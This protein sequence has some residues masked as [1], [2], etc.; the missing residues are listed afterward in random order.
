MACSIAGGLSLSRYGEAMELIDIGVNLSSD[1]FD[2]DREDVLERALA[3]G[4]C[5]MMLTG[6]SLESS[7]EA[8]ERARSRPGVLFATA[9]VH[10]HEASRWDPEA[11]A[12]IRQLAREPE[13]V[14]IGECG[15]DFNR[16]Y[17]PRPQQEA[18]FEAQLAIAA[19]VGLP[20][21]LHE[22]DSSERFAEILGRWRSRLVGG[23]VH[24]FT[25]S[26]SALETWLEM[27][28]YI[29]VTG[30]ICDERRGQELQALVGQI[31]LDRLLLETDAPWLLP[32]DLRPRPAKGRNEPAFLAHICAAVARFGGHSS[33]KLARCST[34]NARRLFGLA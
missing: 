21:F 25:G 22:R 23:V 7:R 29:G 5:Q 30:W 33:E 10:P 15:L 1:R 28:M 2:A 12:S 8:L 3:A 6:S 26:E 24:C 4:V 9:G 31:P 18:A 17:S 20:V 14:A 32:R 13:V 34:E 16:D 11:A 19:D 27:D